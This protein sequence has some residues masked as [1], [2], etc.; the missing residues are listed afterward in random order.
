MALHVVI[1]G[2]LP[3]VFLYTSNISESLRG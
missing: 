3:P 1:F 2:F